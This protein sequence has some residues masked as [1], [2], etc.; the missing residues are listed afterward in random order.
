MGVRGR[1]SIQKPPTLYIHIVWIFNWWGWSLLLLFKQVWNEPVFFFVS[2]VSFKQ[3]VREEKMKLI[4]FTSQLGAILSSI[5]LAI[6]TSSL[7]WNYESS[8]FKLLLI[9]KQTATMLIQ[10]RHFPTSHTWFWTD[11]I[12]RGG[13][14]GEVCAWHVLEPIAWPLHPHLTQ[15]LV[16][17][18]NKSVS[19]L[20]F[21][22]G[23]DL[24]GGHNGYYDSCQ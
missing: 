9:F 21:E 12:I 6:L 10:F 14:I 24:P 17:C 13:K 8:F 3:E 19:Y 18:H 5:F 7:S 23:F 16:E 1:P 2:I 4:L 22:S 15:L 20:Y 11:L